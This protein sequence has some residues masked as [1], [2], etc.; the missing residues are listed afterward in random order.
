MTKEFKQANIN[1]VRN[2][3]E[4]SESS[5]KLLKKATH[6]RNPVKNE[7]SNWVK[8]QDNISN[9]IKLIAG[10]GNTGRKYSNTYHNAG[11]IFID[12]LLKAQKAKK[13]AKDTKTFSAYKLNDE[14]LAVKSK[15]YMNNSGIAIKDAITSLR[16]PL[17]EI[18][19]AHDDSDIK[20]G[21]YKLSFGRGSAGHNGVASIIDKLGSNNF[22]RLRIG[23][24]DSISKEKAADFVLESIPLEQKEILNKICDEIIQTLISS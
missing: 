2:S 24:R 21:S 23:V 9:G 7:I 16:I 22:W 13:T 14:V 8:Q 11:I 6:I 3:C 12:A 5:R 4:I 17:D 19:I 10:I 20:L 1:P 15:T 18:L